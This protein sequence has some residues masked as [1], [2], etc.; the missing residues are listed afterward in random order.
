[1]LC[2]ENLKVYL[3][4]WH[5]YFSKLCN[6][7]AFSSCPDLARQSWLFVLVNAGSS[8]DIPGH[9]ACFRRLS[10]HINPNN[11]KAT[12]VSY[13]W[14]SCPQEPFEWKVLVGFQAHLAK[15]TFPFP[16]RQVALGPSETYTNIILEHS[17]INQ[18]SI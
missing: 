2:L 11:N 9:T 5:A 6:H 17:D 10:A 15:D 1:M 16:I 3:P 7:L 13:P 18:R 12:I 4:V 14:T 8:K